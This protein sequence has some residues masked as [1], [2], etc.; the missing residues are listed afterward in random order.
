MLWCKGH[1]RADTED[2]P[3]PAAPRPA[4]AKVLKSPAGTGNGRVIATGRL[5]ES[6][7][8]RVPEPDAAQGSRSRRADGEAPPRGPAP[9]ADGNQ[10][11]LLL[12]QPPQ[13]QSS[14]STAPGAV[15]AAVQT[16][17]IGHLLPCVSPPTL[18]GYQAAGGH[19]VFCLTVD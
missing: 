7:S 19:I 13:T 12:T 17:S 10:A 18:F 11:R 15:A 6:R 9:Q 2:Q 5:R 14:G 3:R 16:S 1:I 4:A 8:S